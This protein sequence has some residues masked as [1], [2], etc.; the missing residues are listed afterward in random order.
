MNKVNKS[1]LRLIVVELF[2]YNI[3]RGRFLFV[4]RIIQA[5]KSSPFNT[6]VYAA[7]VCVINSKFPQIGELIVKCLISSFCLIYQQND[8]ISSQA[9][10]KFLAHLVNQNVV[11]I[12]F[13]I[14]KT[15]SILSFLF[16]FM[17]LL[18]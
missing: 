4:H 18:H 8:K 5:Q 14:N 15:N 9:T 13:L 6:P 16:R 12:L 7:L 3:I 17:K 1:N 11:C 2:K 10:T